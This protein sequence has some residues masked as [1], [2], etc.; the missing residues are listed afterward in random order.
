[1]VTGS[2]S[3]DCPSFV[4]YASDTTLNDPELLLVN[5]GKDDRGWNP[6]DD[7]DE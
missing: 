2:P 1:M 3:P 4:D 5:E 7:D 6:C